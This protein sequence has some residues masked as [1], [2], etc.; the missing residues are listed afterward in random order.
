MITVAYSLIRKVW[1]YIKYA[2]NV[3][4]FQANFD[5]FFQTIFF[6]F[7]LYKMILIAVNPSALWKASWEI[8]KDKSII[9]NKVNKV[10]MEL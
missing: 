2:K 5:I 3:A 9:D 6:V 7:S 4:F 8:Q 1:I 10:H